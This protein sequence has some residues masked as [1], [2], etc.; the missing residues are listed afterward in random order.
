MR[1]VTKVQ[2]VDAKYITTPDITSD[3][4]L[5]LHEAY[6]YV[7]RYHNSLLVTFIEEVPP[8]SY[9]ARL[10]RTVCFWKRALVIKG[11]ILPE[12]ALVSRSRVVETGV[13]TAVAI[14]S[15]VTVHWY[16]VVY[17]ANVPVRD[18]HTMR[19][20]GV[21]ERVESDRI[22]VRNP[23]T[24]RIQPRPHRPHAQGATYLIIPIA[25]IHTFQEQV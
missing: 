12:G 20:Q 22:I 8:A 1:T 21:L 2:Y 3:T 9:S 18:S 24:V 4:T 11:L 19:T 15:P 13:Y 6:G 7:S 23:T 17:L 10:Y 25:F 5:T 14:G 16:D